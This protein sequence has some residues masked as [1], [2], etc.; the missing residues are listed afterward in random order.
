MIKLNTAEQFVYSGG[1]NDIPLAQ[2]DSFI[3][4]PSFI[5]GINPIHV[6][7]RKSS[8]FETLNGRLFIKTKAL[9]KFHG[10]L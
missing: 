1:Q 6:H 8:M 2:R 4:I 9:H 10:C 7:F 5:D 3:F